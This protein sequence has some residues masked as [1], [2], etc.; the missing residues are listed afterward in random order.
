MSSSTEVARR[1]TEAGLTPSAFEPLQAPAAPPSPAHEAT[2]TLAAAQARADEIREQARAA[3]LAQGHEEGFAA[4]LAAAALELAPAAAA[5]EQALAHQR[6][7]ADDL[8]D[9]LEHQAAELALRIAEKVV[10]ATVE[11]AP[12]RVVDV[13]RAG[14]GC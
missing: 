2:L 7:R 9:S 4:G 11:L 3:G 12:E 14:C 8:V 10:A 1:S 13:V 6:Q 5:L